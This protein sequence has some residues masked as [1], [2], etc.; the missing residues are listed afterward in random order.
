MP[1]E[2]DAGSPKLRENIVRILGSI[3]RHA[4]KRRPPTIEDARG[5]QSE[6]MRGLNADD[7]KYV[8]A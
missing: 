6:L 2:W 8:G 4:P 5:G 1:P 7:A 3:E